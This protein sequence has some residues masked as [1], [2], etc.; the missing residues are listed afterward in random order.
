MAMHGC[1]TPTLEHG[2]L[3]QKYGPLSNDVNGIL[4]LPEGFSFKTIARAGKKMDDGFFR[5]DKPDGMATFAGSHED[6]VILLC[7]HELMPAD[8]GPFGSNGRL[9]KNLPENKIYDLGKDGNLCNGGVTTMVYDEKEGKLTQSFLSL[10]GTLRNC[11]GGKTPWGSWISCEEI[12]TSPNDKLIKDHGF[13]FEV[14]ATS[15]PH[16]SDPIPLIDMGKFNHEAVCIDPKTSI[17]YQTEDR[18]DGLIYRFIPNTKQKLQD[19]GKLQVLVVKD[20]Q[21]LDTRNW[22]EPIVEIGQKLEVEWMD[23]DDVLSPEDDLRVRGFNNGAAVFARGEGMW[24]GEGELY[25]ACTNGGPKRNGQVFKYTLSRYEGQPDESEH[26]GKLELFV[27][28]D[29]EDLLQNCDN[30]TIAPWGDVIVC[31]DN[32]QPKIIGITPEGR[33]YHIAENI[34]YKS[35]FAGITFSPSGKTLFVNIQH[36]GMTLAITGPW[37]SNR[38]QI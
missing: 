10:A 32:M 6:E 13:N 35:E 4:N 14:K 3:I 7:N 30:L 24:F 16:I 23:I 25:F 29:H 33:L 26:P 5:P 8:L 12:V 9:L 18:P 15:T 11:A 2:L 19:G 36:E 34:G 1:E 38:T 20:Q 21:G 31:E 22:V 27:E 17:V 37:M 28:S